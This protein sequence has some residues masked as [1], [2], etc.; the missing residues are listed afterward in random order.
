M[1]QDEYEYLSSCPVI[2]HLPQFNNSIVVH[3]GLDPNINSL[4][5]QVPFLVMN[6]RDIDKDNQPSK[7][8]D[9][10]VQWAEEWNVYQD[11]ST[12]NDTEI[13]YGHDASRGLNIQEH[14]FGVDTGCVYGR[15]LTAINMQTKELTSVKCKAYSK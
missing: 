9:V 4:E 3:G 1:T 13:F 11:N 2:L 15:K 10:G 5:G 12:I 14:T 8:N 7:D 6:M